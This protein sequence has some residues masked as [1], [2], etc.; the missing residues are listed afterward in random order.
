MK[1]LLK[2]LLY[3]NTYHSQHAAVVAALTTSSSTG[4]GALLLASLYILGVYNL[5]RSRVSDGDKAGDPKR[6]AFVLEHLM[7]YRRVA[8]SSLLLASF[9]A[10]YHQLWMVVAAIVAGIFYTSWKASFPGAKNVGVPLCWALVC[11][12]FS[13]GVPY[14]AFAFVFLWSASV[15]LLNDVGDIEEDRSE[16]IRSIAVMVGATNAIRIVRAMRISSLLCL[17]ATNVGVWELAPLSFVAIHGAFIVLSTNI[18][19]QTR[20]FFAHLMS[21]VL[22]WVFKALL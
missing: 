15:V 12:A 14:L 22:F 19:L 18:Q 3:F 13:P 11:T 10:V 9:I 4:G 20:V 8:W 5:D 16:G 6:S 2:T 17:L 7:A 1:Q 21:D